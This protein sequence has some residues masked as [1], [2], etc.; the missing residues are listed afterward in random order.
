MDDA[1]RRGRQGAPAVGG[2]HAVT[3]ARRGCPVPGPGPAATGAARGRDRGEP[4]RGAALDCR[5]GSGRAPGPPLR[6]G[7]RRHRGPGLR[8]QPD[9]GPCCAHRLSPG[10]VAA[11]R[12]R[13]GRGLPPD[14]R[15]ERGHP[16]GTNLGGGEPADRVGVRAGVGIR[17]VRLLLAGRRARIGPL[18]AGDRGSGRGHQ[19]RRTAPAVAGSIARRRSL[20]SGFR[21]RARTPRQTRGVAPALRCRGARPARGAVGGDVPGGRTPGPVRGGADRRHRG[22]RGHISRSRSHRAEPSCG[23]RV[24]RSTGPGHCPG[25]GTPRS[26][27]GAISIPTASRSSIGSAPGCHRPGP[28]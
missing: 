27:T 10:V 5:S 12:R 18:P 19:V 23:A 1:G 6:V 26:G 16:A 13:D 22:E 17:R 4:G 2:R 15:A 8:S 20:R 28:C 14:P 9:S 25:C 11:G 3:R 7:L 24:S 21:R